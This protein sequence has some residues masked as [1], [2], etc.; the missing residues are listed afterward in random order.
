MGDPE[1]K[2]NTKS[3]SHFIITADFP[4]Y[5]VKGQDFKFHQFHDILLALS[6]AHMQRVTNKEDIDFIPIEKN[7][8][9]QK[10]ID[11]KML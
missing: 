8:I 11:K 9:L 7:I 4:A 3:L 6:K 10:E 1:W 5:E 2:A